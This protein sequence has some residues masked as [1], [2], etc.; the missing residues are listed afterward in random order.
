MAATTKRANFDLSP[1]QEA[2]LANLRAQ[3]AASSTKEAV[4]RAVEVTT[5]L[6]GEVQRG[7]RLFVGRSPTTAIRLAIPELEAR[8]HG[9]WR[10]LVE[11]PHPWRRQLWVKGRK[12]LASAVWLDALTNGMGPSEAAENWDLPLEAS[13][14]IFAYCEANK[15]LI[16]SEANEERQRLKRANVD[17]E[18]TAPA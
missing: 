14:E 3:L 6:L 15:A 1:E 17:V 12:L 8:A 10:W 4:L 13:E 11:R 2:L 16:E 7:N 9:Q 5:L 18:A